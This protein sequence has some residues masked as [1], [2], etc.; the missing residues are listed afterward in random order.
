MRRRGKH[1]PRIEEIFTTHYEFAAQASKQRRHSAAQPW[2]FAI[3]LVA[4]ACAGG[5]IILR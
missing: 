5:S 3:L 1:V 2:V 4:L